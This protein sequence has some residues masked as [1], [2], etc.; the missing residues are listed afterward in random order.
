MDPESNLILPVPDWLLTPL[1]TEPETLS[2]WGFPAEGGKPHAT[3]F[4]P[5]KSSS[6]SAL[7]WS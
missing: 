4:T 1:H 2:E 7:N 3:Q 5:K 6:G